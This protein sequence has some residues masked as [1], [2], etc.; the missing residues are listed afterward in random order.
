MKKKTV[1]LD[2]EKPIQD[3]NLQIDELKNLAATNHIDLSDEIDRMEQRALALKQRIYTSLAPDQVVKIAR[4]AERP[5]TLDYIGMMCTDFV[6]VH[7][8]RL[9]GDDPSI[10]G[11][12]A[13]LGDQKIMILGHQK[14]KD[15]KDKIYRN[16]GMPQPE[17]YRKAMRLMR[18]A[19]K[20]GLPIV[21]LVDTPGA[22]P[23]IEA[24]ER[25]QAEAIARNLY[26][27]SALKVPVFTIITGEGGSGGALGIAVANEVLILEHAVY[28][29]ISP[30]GCAAILWSDAS[31]SPD[32]AK[33]MKMTSKELKQL[34]VVDDIIPEPVGGAHHDP[35]L[36]ASNVSATISKLLKK[37]KKLKPEQIAEHRYSKFRAFG[38][39][40]EE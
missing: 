13:R 37:Y 26:D 25:G 30:E 8:D 14:G 23:G 5:T 24:E 28:S 7:G 18:L 6:E 22:F 33:A 27:M 10:V 29:V 38:F 32:A 12:F 1:I 9:F 11:G 19:E 17:G 16:F 35:D 15:T 20:F 2:F 21:T 40:S 39:F 4:H 3:L 31:R 36:V 34:G